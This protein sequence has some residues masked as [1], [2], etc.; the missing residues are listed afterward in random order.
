MENSTLWSAGLSLI[1]ALILLWINSVNNEAKRIS[2]L[3]SKTREEN[4]EKYMT[5][6]E[7]H[8]EINRVLDRLDRLENKIDLFIREQKSALN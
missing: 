7:V 4:A 2:I 3:L 8:G 5:K 1:S 6:N